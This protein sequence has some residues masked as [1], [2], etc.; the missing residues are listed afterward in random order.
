MT[1]SSLESE[2]SERDTFSVYERKELIIVCM[3]MRRGRIYIS[4]LLV[5]MLF[6]VQKLLE[7]RALTKTTPDTLFLCVCS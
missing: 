3:L 4:H 5:C 6:E 1:W 2:R 7:A